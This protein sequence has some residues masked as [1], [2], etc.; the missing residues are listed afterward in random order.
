MVW[1]SE[2]SL[3]SIFFLAMAC[4]HWLSVSEPYPNHHGKFNRSC[5]SCL[6]YWSKWEAILLQDKLIDG[7]TGSTRYSFLTI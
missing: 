1:N 5:N 3:G 2:V 7:F 6:M 4:N